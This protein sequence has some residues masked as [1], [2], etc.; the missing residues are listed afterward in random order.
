VRIAGFFGVNVPMEA[1]GF[2]LAPG[3]VVVRPG[4]KSAWLDDLYRLMFGGLSFAIK[5]GNEKR[6][7]QL[8]SNPETSFPFPKKVL[9]F[10][11]T[12]EL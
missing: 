6:G 10:F 5:K 8:S 7:V 1:H 9:D 4:H 2:K 12:I 3:P 11:E